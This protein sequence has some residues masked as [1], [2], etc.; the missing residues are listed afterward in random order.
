M[1]RNHVL[2]AALA[3][4]MA[5][6][7]ALYAFGTA[8]AADWHAY[9]GDV[10]A[11][12]AY[13]LQ[14]PPDAKGLEVKYD[15]NGSAALALYDPFGA[16]VGFYSLDAS[17]PAAD[18]ASPQTG[19]YVLYVYALKDG[20]LHVAVNSA[21]APTPAL[22][23]LPLQRED[24]AI[25]S[26]DE[27]AALDKAMTATFKAPPMFVT[28]L[29]EGSVQG[30]NADVA[31]LKGSVLTVADESGSAFSPGVFTDQSGHR[32]STFANV[33]GASYTATAHAKSFQGTLYLAALS[34]Q[35]PKVEPVVDAPAA[36]P[37]PTG[38]P[39][40]P[41]PA[42]AP[43]PLR[44]GEGHAYAFQAQPGPLALSDPKA[45]SNGTRVD[46]RILVYS[47]EDKLLQEVRLNSTN[48]GRSTIS[49]PMAGEYVAYVERASG[50]AVYALPEGGSGEARDLALGHEE[51]RFSPD[52]SGVSGQSTTFTLQHVPVAVA[53]DGDN[54]TTL[55]GGADVRNE[56][57][58]VAA[59]SSLVQTPGLGDV[60]GSQASFPE[61]FAS[62]EHVVEAW[63]FT[64]GWI[65]VK[66]TYYQRDAPLVPATPAPVEGDNAT[67]NETGNNTTWDPATPIGPLPWG[68]STS[69]LL[70]RLAAPRLI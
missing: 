11:G 30:L 39:P 35:P 15:G 58:T 69:P 51:F 29:Y 20:A 3:M 31:S 64:Q 26:F 57:G 56:K 8:N 43:A 44:L 65:A 13:G 62:G 61:N 21:K 32:A 42:P 23:P 55:L 25:A 38:T 33:E 10:Y 59:W 70:P 52:P 37:A 19:T 60:A 27:P 68:G 28:L 63:Q 66:V 54:A 47:P 4:A 41:A 7:V 45:G 34:L 16:K 5:G 17:L 14:V 67:A 50:L 46:D 9:T 12:H 18:L 48:G 40:A 1:Q 49:L 22:Q 24:V 6:G 2:A 53:L 36:P